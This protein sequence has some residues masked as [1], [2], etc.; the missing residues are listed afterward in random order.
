VKRKKA[1]TKPFRFVILLLIPVLLLA[2]IAGYVLWEKEWKAAPAKVEKPAG[3]KTI[4]KQEP[5]DRDRRKDG[6]NRVA[7]IID[8]IGYDLD[9]A[10]EILDLPVPVALAILPHCPYSRDVALLARKENRE[11]LLHLPMEPRDYPRTDSGEGTL[12]CTMTGEEV[13]GELEKN[14]EAVP[15]AVGVN[16]HMGS[17]FMEDGERLEMVFRR[18]K[19]RGLFFVDSLTTGNSRGGE[20]ARRVD[21][22]FAVRDAF[23][24]NG[25][26]R[27]GTRE[28]FDRLLERRAYW[29]ELV[30]IGHPYRNTVDLLKD[31]IPK[32]E[33]AGIRFVR[34][35]SVVK[36]E[37]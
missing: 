18:L 4:R 7:L 22:P 35:S 30:L 3:K 31:M 21:L 33:K 20:K 8:D 11:I 29:T 17:L 1:R 12:L 34:V 28:V 36:R 27:E 24:D 2:V 9:V 10:R 37:S 16:N 19:K 15:G 14:L 23:I 6:V 5:P 32:L 26:L 13:I 25:S